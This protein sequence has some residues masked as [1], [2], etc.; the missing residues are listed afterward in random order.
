MDI[1]HAINLEIYKKFEESD[2][3]FAYPTQ[4]LLLEQS[5]KFFLDKES[6][7][8]KLETDSLRSAD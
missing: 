2:I 8:N 3:N 7:K 1:Q 5:G 4:T 6:G